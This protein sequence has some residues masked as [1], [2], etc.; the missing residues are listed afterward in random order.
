MYSCSVDEYAADDENKGGLYSASLLHEAIKWS[1]TQQVES[2][3]YRV[4]TVASAHDK[5][6]LRVVA[7]RPDRQD[8][9]IVKPRSVEKYFP[10]AI[11]T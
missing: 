10:F 2:G 3:Y 8:P 6:K 1:R 5:A 7:E 4:L 11:V 9:T